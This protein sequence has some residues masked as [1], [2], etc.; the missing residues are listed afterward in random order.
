MTI[1]TTALFPPAPCS[2]GEQPRRLLRQPG[3][4]RRAAYHR[5]PRRDLGPA[6]AVASQRR[7]GQRLGAARHCV[8]PHGRR[9]GHVRGAGRRRRRA[10][11]RQ[12]GRRR[13]NDGREADPGR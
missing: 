2:T 7:P 9:G 3:D 8:Q 10:V 1:P 4:H 5:V 12:H 13:R 11:D 6:E